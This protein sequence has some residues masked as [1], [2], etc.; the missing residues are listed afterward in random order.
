MQQSYEMN[1]NSPTKVL[2][3]S[4]I[5]SVIM[6]IFCN[7]ITKYYV[8]VVF[9][10]LQTMFN[11]F[12]MNAI[13]RFRWRHWRPWIAPL[14]IPHSILETLIT[15]FYDGILVLYRTFIPPILSFIFSIYVFLLW[16]NFLILCLLCFYFYSWLFTPWLFPF[17]V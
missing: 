12:Y 3:L 4:F 17:L 7:S 13:K 15:Q 14:K 1:I 11:L 10:F 16:R 5:L 6:N 9:S 8:H 2:F